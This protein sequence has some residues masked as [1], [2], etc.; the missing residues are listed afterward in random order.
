M[1]LVITMIFFMFSIVISL[2]YK[3]I[4]I[5]NNIVAIKPSGVPYNDLKIDD[6][7]ILNLKGEILGY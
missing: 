1:E 4:A 7:V 5:N 2:I 3:K 6:I